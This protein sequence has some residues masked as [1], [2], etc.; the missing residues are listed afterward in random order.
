[1]ISEYKAQHVVRE[2]LVFLKTLYFFADSIFIK[3]RKRI[4]ALA[5][6]MA[7]S[8]FSLHSGTTTTACGFTIIK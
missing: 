6:M 8:R 5:M 2:D 7:L 3:T 4:E 1:M